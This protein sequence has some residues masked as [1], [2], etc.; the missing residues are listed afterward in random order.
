M[1]ELEKNLYPA[2]ISQLHMALRLD[3]HSILPIWQSSQWREQLEEVALFPL[4]RAPLA[5]Q[6][7][8]SAIEQTSDVPRRDAKQRRMG[9]HLALAPDAIALGRIGIQPEPGRINSI[10][11]ELPADV[12]KAAQIQPETKMENSSP[13]LAKASLLRHWPKRCQR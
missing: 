2:K 8:W 5:A 10:R 3:L 7:K 9:Y 13:V 1:I 6:D 12:C 11:I 4:M